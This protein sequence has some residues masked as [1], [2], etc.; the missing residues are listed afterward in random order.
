MNFRMAFAD[1]LAISAAVGGAKLPNAS[2]RVA[3][4]NC[5]SEGDCRAAQM[6][7]RVTMPSA[8]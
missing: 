5:P 1:A 8:T 7:Q 6:Q 3:F 4:T 2:A